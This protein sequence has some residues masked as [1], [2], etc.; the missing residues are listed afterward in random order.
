MSELLILQEVMQR[1]KWKE[2]LESMPLPCE[3]FDMI[4]GTGTGGFVPMITSLNY[5]WVLTLLCF[6]RLIALML[7]R[8]RMSISDAI[9]SYDTLAKRVFFEGKKM[10]GDGKFKT[11]ILEAVMKEIVKEKTDDADT[12]MMD[13]SSDGV[14]CKTY[15]RSPF[16]VVLKGDQVSVLCVLELRTT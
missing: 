4:G 12:R 7:G 11:S 13:T 10:T 8:L 9:Q 6:S 1:I 16:L 2:N 15:V 5:V 3:Y 14:T